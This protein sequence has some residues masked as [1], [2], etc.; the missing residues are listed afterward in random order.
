MIVVSDTGPLNY[1]IQIGCVDVLPTLF[2]TVH[3]PLAVAEELRHPRTPK[4]VL[5]WMRAPPAWLVLSSVSSRT[6]PGGLDRG[7]SEAIAL[8]S[9]LHADLLVDDLK[10]KRVAMGLGIRTIGLLAL[11]RIASERG[12]IDLLTTLDR[13]ESTSFFV[14]RELVDSMRQDEMRRREARP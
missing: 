2:V 3:V 1:A 10:A 9:E 11:L 6:V 4:V 13:L 7:E 8:A 12:L 5:D 14:P